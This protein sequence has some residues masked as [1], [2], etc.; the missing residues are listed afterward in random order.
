MFRV[1]WQYVRNPRATP[2]L[3]PASERFARLGDLIFADL[4]LAGACEPVFRRPGPVLARLVRTLPARFRD[5][6]ENDLGSY[7]HAFVSAREDASRLVDRLRQESSVRFAE[8]QQR[9]EPA[10]ILDE[11]R[12]TRARHRSHEVRESP[13]ETRP[14]PTFTALQAYLDPSPVGVGLSGVVDE[15]DGARG[16]SIRIADVETGWSFLHANLRPL[17]LGVAF[18]GNGGCRDHGTAVL[19]LLAGCA[20]G[21]GI[22][23]A[24]P[25]AL[26][27]GYSADLDSTARGW[28]VADSIRAAAECLTAGDVILLGL[29]APGPGAHGRYRQRG[30]LPVEYGRAEVAA[31]RLAIARGIHV[32]E[33]AGNGATSLDDPACGDRFDRASGDSGAILVGGGASAFQPDARSRLWWSNY[34]SRV[35]VH[36]W[37]EDI[38]TCGG[39][40][41]PSAFD[42]FDDPDP[43]R[44]YTQ[45]FGGTSGAAA[46]V[47]AVVASIEGALRAAGRPSLP[48]AEMRDLLVRT[49][50]PQ[51][52]GPDGPA[53]E[54]IGPLPD[55]R[56]ALDEL[57]LLR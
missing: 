48:P 8:L 6:P 52:E 34:G 9:P 57:G 49:G 51:T 27:A 22:Q 5:L 4:G 41:E 32:V 46:L 7:L 26:C 29:H 19:G 2:D 13:L 55:A 36:A 44:C 20:G 35:D 50:A 43:L 53:S 54:R 25:E 17:H 23:G 21:A 14:I 24:V 16:S 56:A 38:V 3:V 31:I 15:L 47:A 1:V 37:G 12:R 18:G 33:S 28:N 11:S 30:F 45:S 39:R 40:D 10:F 42:L